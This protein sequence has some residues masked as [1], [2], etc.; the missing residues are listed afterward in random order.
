MS[1]PRPMC[2]GLEDRD[3]PT[4]REKL[5]WEAQNA[6]VINRRILMQANCLQ[7]RCGYFFTR[8]CNWTLKP[9]DSSKA[10]SVAKLLT[11]SEQKLAPTNSLSP[12]IR[13]CKQKNG[14][15]KLLI[16]HRNLKIE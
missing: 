1:G 6:S 7:R 8:F 2:Y 3:S 14:Q 13:L 5:S 15:S 10:S 12:K 9:E 4:P 16:R 11:K